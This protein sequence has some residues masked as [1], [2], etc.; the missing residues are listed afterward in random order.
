[1]RDYFVSVEMDI[2]VDEQRCVILLE[3]RIQAVPNIRRSYVFL[4]GRKSIFAVS[5]VQSPPSPP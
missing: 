1:M 4:R 2:S 5:Q 3:Y